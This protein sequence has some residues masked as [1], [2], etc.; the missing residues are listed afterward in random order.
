MS[1]ADYLHA[2]QDMKDR[3][4]TTAQSYLVR[5]GWQGGKPTDQQKQAAQQ[6]AKSE[7]QNF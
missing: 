1:K 4:A 6:L 5:I 7:G 2:Q 3:A